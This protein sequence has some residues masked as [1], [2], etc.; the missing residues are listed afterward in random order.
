MPGAF[1]CCFRLTGQ[2]LRALVTVIARDVCSSTEGESIF[3]H[4]HAWVADF[5]LRTVLLND[6]ERN[7]TNPRNEL[8]DMRARSYN[9]K[10]IT[11]MLAFL[12]SIIRSF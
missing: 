4:M 8:D 9:T 7:E 12:R 3:G 2:R 5:D 11:F 1:R 10:S 6:C